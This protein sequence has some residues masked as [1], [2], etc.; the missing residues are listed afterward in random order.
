MVVCSFPLFYVFDFFPIFRMA[1][2]KGEGEE[3]CRSL[4]SDLKLC[5]SGCQGGRKQAG[6]K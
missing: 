2:R 5:K 3:S 4:S 1:N 6:K